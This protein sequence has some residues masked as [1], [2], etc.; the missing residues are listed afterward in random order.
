M[1]ILT[2]LVVT[3]VVEQSVLVPAF[4]L[5]EE[6]VEKASKEAE[7][8]VTTKLMGHRLAVLLKELSDMGVRLASTKSAETRGPY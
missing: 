7:A 3:P 2:E 4:R 6:E 8:F 1:S 5:S